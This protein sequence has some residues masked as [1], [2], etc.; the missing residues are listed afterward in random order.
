MSNGPQQG[1]FGTIPVDEQT[2]ILYW[3][4]GSWWNDPAPFNPWPTPD[5]DTGG[6]QHHASFFPETQSPIA[7][8]PGPSNGFTFNFPELPC[9]EPN[10]NT[11]TTA[12]QIP[13][14]QP[15]RSPT[16]EEA[17]PCPINKPT[18]AWY[19]E[20]TPNGR[21][22]KRSRQSPGTTVPN[23]TAEPPKPTQPTGDLNGGPPPPN[24]NPG[25]SRRVCAKSGDS[26]C[27]HRISPQS[28][29]WS[30][31]VVPGPWEF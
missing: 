15:A 8:H 3:E 22:K 20:Q 11:N 4:D 1:S 10:A 6:Q 13:T 5:D 7:D 14:V 18:W 23:S 29:G 16:P 25:R 19:V 28:G 30:T 26:V 27:S 12:V 9:E 2:T 21:F 17:V 24:S 31:P